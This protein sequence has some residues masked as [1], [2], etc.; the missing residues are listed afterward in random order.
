[1]GDFG[2]VKA[3]LNAINKISQCHFVVFH[4]SDSVYSSVFTG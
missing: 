1:V 4:V 2:A 3:H